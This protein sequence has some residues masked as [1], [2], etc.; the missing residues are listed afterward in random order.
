M[1][2]TLY[3]CTKDIYFLHVFLTCSSTMQ[4]LGNHYM[5]VIVI[6]KSQVDFS[7]RHTCYLARARMSPSPDPVEAIVGSWDLGV[8]R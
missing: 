8:G 1:V 6:S 7:Q 2:I 4:K 3:P 5:D